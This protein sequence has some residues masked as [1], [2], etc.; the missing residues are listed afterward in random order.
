MANGL[1][2]YKR[3]LYELK[4]KYKDYQQSIEKDWADW[5]KDNP[6]RRA[7]NNKSKGT[8]ADAYM[9]KD[10]LG[11]K[12]QIGYA[13]DQY[14]PDYSIST[15]S[16]ATD[17]VAFQGKPKSDLTGKIAGS[18]SDVA[19]LAG[20]YIG[21]LNSE[22]ESKAQ[23]R[24]NTA[25]LALNSAVTGA[26]LGGT[27]GGPIGAG[28]GAVVGGIGGLIVGNKKAGKE[29]KRR[30]FKLYGEQQEEFERLSSAREREESM[31]ERAEQL[32]RLSKLRSSQLN[33]FDIKY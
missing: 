26:K 9:L 5:T 13:I 15:P 2:D 27:I 28:I 18:I 23:D 25:N 12:S 19:N 11:G 21:V 6:I 8:I 33:Y 30:N 32:D 3:D 24:S 7:M 14:S 16:I 10:T 17:D 1:F 31:S 4:G 22:S 29:L 20:T